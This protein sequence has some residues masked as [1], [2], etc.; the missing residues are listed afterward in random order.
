VNK[1]D[2]DWI[3][4]L[5]ASV[6]IGDNTAFLAPLTS[7]VDISFAD[8]SIAGVKGLSIQ[9]DRDFM[10]RIPF[11]QQVLVLIHELWHIARLHE[12]RRGDRDHKIWNM[13]C[14]IRINNDMV[15][16]GLMIDQVE[17]FTT[18][19][20]IDRGLSRSEEDIYTD[21]Y[22]DHQ[23]CDDKESFFS[24]YPEDLP[25]SSD[26]G[27]SDYSSE[28]IE[29]V[30][31]QSMEESKQLT[32][33]TD[34]C[35]LILGFLDKITGRTIPVR[36]LIQN[37]LEQAL[38]SDW[39][40]AKPNRRH[41]EY[42]PSTIHEE[43]VDC[44]NIWLDTS[45]SMTNDDVSIVLDI[46]N[47]I[48]ANNLSCETVLWQFDTEIHRRDSFSKDMQ[49][50]LDLIGRGGTDVT[51]VMEK[52]SEFPSQVHLLVSDLQ[53]DHVDIPSQCKKVVILSPETYNRD[54]LYT[55]T[56]FVY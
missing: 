49:P 26:N 11:K 18:N 45:G 36:I 14:D 32:C 2:R 33:S 24:E 40:W 54:H 51:D 27:M 53:F 19:T 30:V 15:K 37:W 39:S 23:Y 52:M 31:R 16:D 56:H 22:E 5:K 44:I 47:S 42:L 38:L 21:L 34:K 48:H 55:C 3:E 7:K 6:Y 1:S 29:L 41:E 17:G 35:G 4:R 13:A 12:F 8:V 46:I 25:Q 9:L 50:S 20:G 43:S 10:S 28:D